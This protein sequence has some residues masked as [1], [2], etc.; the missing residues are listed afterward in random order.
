VTVGTT[1]RSVTVLTVTAKR[2]LVRFE[3]GGRIHY[4][5]FGNAAFDPALP[6]YVELLPGEG[7][8][9]ARITRE[10]KTLSLYCPCPEAIPRTHRMLR[11]RR[12]G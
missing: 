3:R 8:T 11:N 1:N 5:R 7:T 12:K 6:G 10:S 2:V 9:T 4:L